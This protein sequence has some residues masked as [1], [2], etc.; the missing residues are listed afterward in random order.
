[1]TDLTVDQFPRSNRYDPHWLMENHM[2]PNVLWLT[3][4]VTQV[5]DLQPGMKVLDLGCP[6]RRPRTAPS[7]ERKLLGLLDQ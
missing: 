7:C 1:M 3:E 4:S 6:C 5:F 2:G